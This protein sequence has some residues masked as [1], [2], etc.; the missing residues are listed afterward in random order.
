M[1]DASSQ[2]DE[3]ALLLRRYRDRGD[4][5]AREELAQRYLPLA[6]RL[7][8]RYA[9]GEQSL[10]D[11]VQV[12]SLGL[13]K[14][15]DR[16]DPDQGARFSTY[17]IPTILGELK[18]HLRD[19][20]WSVHVPR[21]VQE[22]TLKVVQASADL[23]QRLGRS[24]RVSEIAEKTRFTEVEVLEALDAAGAREALSLDAGPG[25]D[26]DAPTYD[27][28]LGAED[29]RF[30]LVELGASIADAFAAL[31]ERE[32]MVLHLR[33][34]EDMTQTAIA[35][36]VGVSQMHVSRLIRRSLRHLRSAAGED[37]LPEE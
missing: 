19:T 24:P 36:R 25:G 8:M 13:A 9:R 14:A 32:R 35:E 26:E 20:G 30:E 17:A 23:T 31:P 7:A 6:R 22:R 16:F 10:E 3:A 4:T 37:E 1:A 18:R 33:F 29:E 12:A 27:Q 15:I 21:G 11:L 2:R 5:L 28:R 34:V